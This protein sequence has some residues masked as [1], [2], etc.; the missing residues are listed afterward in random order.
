MV[1]V[2]ASRVNCSFEH[3]IHGTKNVCREDLVS[4][5]VVQWPSRRVALPHE[6]E[7]VAEDGV[8]EQ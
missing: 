3:S 6:S 2:R 8:R 7:V 5:A 1:R 4:A